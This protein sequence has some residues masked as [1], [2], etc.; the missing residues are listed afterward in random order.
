MRLHLSSLLLLLPWAVTGLR[1]A[2]SGLGF[3]SKSRRTLRGPSQVSSLSRSSVDAKTV[4]PSP[5]ALALV[6]LARVHARRAGRATVGQQPGTGTMVQPAAQLTTQQQA[7]A[8][9][10]ANV[11]PTLPPPLTAANLDVLPFSNLTAMLP[12]NF[13]PALTQMKQLEKSVGTL[14]AKVNN[15][16]AHFLRAEASMRNASDTLTAA[17]KNVY[18]LE[19]LARTN[20]WNLGKTE[21]VVADTNS[22][23]GNEDYSIQLTTPQAQN[24]SAGAANLSSM[25]NQ[26][27]SPKDLAAL[28]NLE[29]TLWDAT[30]RNGKLSIPELEDRLTT[31]KRN[32]TYFREVLDKEVKKILAKEGRPLLNAIRHEVFN[33]AEASYGMKV[34]YDDDDDDDHDGKNGIADGY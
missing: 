15:L 11:T 24:V 7:T 27:A 3:A 16:T 32:I 28:D 1:G 12:S 8:N 23:L 19:F 17:K 21:G 26:T 20:K 4:E 5:S 30:N 13:T 34:S 10:T 22:S 33:L 18:V 14:V 9:A 2:E 31:D 25:A 6:A 29:T